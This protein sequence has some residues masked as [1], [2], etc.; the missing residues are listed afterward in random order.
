MLEN[1]IFFSAHMRTKY[2]IVENYTI[3][4]SGVEQLLWVTIDSN[5]NC[6]EHILFLCKKANRKLHALS[7]VSKYRTLNKRRIL[8]KSFIISQFNYY[9]LIRMMHNRAL[10]NKFNHIHEKAL[11]IVYDDYSSSFEDLPNKD[12]SVTI[13]QRNL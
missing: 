5:L 3:K 2:Q 10:N 7:R 13:H 11:R 9:P 1:S 6:K 4:W 8:M 12:K